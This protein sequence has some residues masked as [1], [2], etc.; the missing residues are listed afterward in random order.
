MSGPLLLIVRK[1]RYSEHTGT[2]HSCQYS[3]RWDATVFEPTGDEGSYALER[4]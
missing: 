2:S 3:R 1:R 4:N